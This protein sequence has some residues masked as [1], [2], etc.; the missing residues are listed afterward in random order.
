ML[1]SGDAGV[2]EEQVDVA[3]LLADLVGDFGEG[4]FVGYVADD[5]LDGAVDG[6]FGGF[7]EGFFTAADDIDCLRAIG[8]KCS[9]SVK[10]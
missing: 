10:T 8:I 6:C 4:F 5:G 7:F 9:R 1:G 3:L 2:G